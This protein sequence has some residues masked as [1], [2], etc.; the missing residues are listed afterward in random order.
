MTI[1][2]YFDEATKTKS[3]T[4]FMYK[5]SVVSIVKYT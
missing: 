1:Q 3:M 5:E 4:T 2:Y